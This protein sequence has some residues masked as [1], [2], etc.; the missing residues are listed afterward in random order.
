M[1][2]DDF[3]N[4]ELK[5]NQIPKPGIRSQLKMAPKG[6]N[7]NYQKN[8]NL[9]F[10]ATAMLLYPR[11]K[12]MYFCLIRRAV[13]TEVHSNQIGFPGGGKEKTD[14]NYW[15]TALRE[16]NE[17]IGVK[18]N[19]VIFITKLSKIFI[20]VSNY[21]VFPYMVRTPKRPT[22]LINKNEVDYL[23]EVKLSML[24]SK[25]SIKTTKILNLEVPIFNFNG[26]EVW[27]ATAMILSE[28]RDLILLSK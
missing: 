20:P 9:K 11:K 14:K 12:S 24:L 3:L 27:G 22:F 23:I 18:R 25:N 2:L 7:L 4:Y 19:Q 28:A 13:T 26:E 1:Q 10:A 5:L 15:E 16:I 8:N 17:E 21:I 6:R